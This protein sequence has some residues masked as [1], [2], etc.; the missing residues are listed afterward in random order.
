MFPDILQ[1]FSGRESLGEK[2]YLVE[3]S[4]TET[5]ISSDFDPKP[6]E[7]YRI[8]DPDPLFTGDPD[9]NSG[10]LAKV[11]LNT[12]GVIIVKLDQEDMLVAN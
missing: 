10:D 6:S 11:D 12:E 3:E 7:Y 9:L 4:D 2:S 1:H 5:L 8:L